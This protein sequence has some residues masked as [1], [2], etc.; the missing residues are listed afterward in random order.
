[1]IVELVSNVTTNTTVALD[2]VVGAIMTNP[3]TAITIIIEFLLGFALGYIAA[4]AIKYLL[5]AAGII[6]LGIFLGI[7]SIGNSIQQSLE[8]LGMIAKQLLNLGYTLASM[9]G[10][11]AVG[12]IAVGFIIG[13]IIAGMRK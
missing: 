5:A 13:A 11:L 9:L 7:W 3:S 8:R 1:M 10:I 6:L 12:P 4:K 2:K